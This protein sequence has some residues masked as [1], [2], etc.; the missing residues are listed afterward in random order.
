MTGKRQHTPGPWRVEPVGSGL[1]VWGLKGTHGMPEYYSP[2]LADL[3]DCPNAEANARL[4]AAAPD[5][6]AL[7]GECRVVLGRLE[8]SWQDDT[9]NECSNFEDIQHVLARLDQTL[10]GLGG[11]A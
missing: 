6:L 9:W 2:V 5:L 8:L 1:Q 7:V 3:S 4:I 11:E 10:A